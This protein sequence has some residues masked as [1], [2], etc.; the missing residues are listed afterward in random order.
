MEAATAYLVGSVARGE[1]DRAKDISDCTQ[2]A[3]S[4]VTGKPAAEVPTV[5]TA[6]EKLVSMGFSPLEASKALLKAGVSP[7]TIEAFANHPYR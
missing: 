7:M 1:A 6:V 3:V 4:Q 5:S 2:Q